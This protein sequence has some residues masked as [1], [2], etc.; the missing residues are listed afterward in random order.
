MYFKLTSGWLLCLQSCLVGEGPKSSS[1]TQRAFPEKAPVRTRQPSDKQVWWQT[2]RMWNSCIE[3]LAEEEVK[4]LGRTRSIC[5]KE[6]STPL[7]RRLEGDAVSRFQKGLGTLLV[8]TA[9]HTDSNVTRQD[10]CPLPRLNRGY[11]R[12]T[13]R[14]ARRWTGPHGLSTMSVSLCHWHK[15]L[16][17]NP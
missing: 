17:L 16:G 1:R 4:A 14:A 2:R 9:P 3:G 12:G 15:L 10:E 11:Q 8:C 13:G 7:Y 6:G 5:F